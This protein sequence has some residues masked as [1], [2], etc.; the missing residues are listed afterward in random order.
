M[1]GLIHGGGE[2]LL[3]LHQQ[4]V[5][6][7]LHGLKVGIGLHFVTENGRIVERGGQ[8]SARIQGIVAHGLQKGHGI[9]I[10]TGRHGLCGFF[11][12]GMDGTH[13]ALMK[14]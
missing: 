13:A 1:L 4:L 12:T 8:D 7:G 2:L 9:Q 3:N 11:Q 10:E 14:T 5:Q 6:H